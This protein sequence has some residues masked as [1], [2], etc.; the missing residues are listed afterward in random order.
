MSLEQALLE[1][2]AALKQLITVLTT[3]AESGA[4]S[5]PTSAPAAATTA[6]R[7]RP[8]KVEQEVAQP[9]E[10]APA[11]QPVV[12]ETPK[13]VEPA[14][15]VQVSSPAAPVAS[16]QQATN[17]QPVTYDMV[18]KRL[19][20]IHEASG[21][22]NNSIKPILDHF[23]VTSVPGLAAKNLSEVMAFIDTFAAKPAGDS[24]FGG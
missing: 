13:P 17:S 10:P 11:V 18:M 22:D 14:P 16:S 20:A 21:K 15:V 4:V 5:A 7:G 9:V 19:L 8:A 12:Q 1:N 2:T 6:K 23:Q 24:L 3:A